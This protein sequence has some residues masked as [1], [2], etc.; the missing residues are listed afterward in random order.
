MRIIKRINHNAVLCVDS[1]GHDVVALGSG[2]GFPDGSN[3]VELQRIERTFYG[4]DDRYLDLMKDIPSDVLGF[5][6][7]MADVIRGVLSYELSPNFPLVLADHI[8]FMIK[9]TRGGMMTNMPLSYDIAQLYPLE[10][11]LATFVID[12]AE[13][14][15]DLPLKRSEVTGVALT[16]LNSVNSDTATAEEGVAVERILDGVTR[17]VEEK[18][19][20]IIDRDGMNYARFATHMHYLLRGLRTAGLSDKQD[21]HMLRQ[22]KNEVPDIV[23][24]ALDVGAFAE[25]E[26]GIHL[27]MSEFVYLAIHINRLYNAA[28][29]G[30][31]SASQEKSI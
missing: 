15:F 18:L 2:I 23:S 21:E 5:S 24:C 8:A 30:E 13:S 16:I 29:G 7:Q 27:G 22:L 25:R 19:S 1:K 11:K 26:A 10:W 20:I 6:A 9:R 4:V 14:T 17:T 12:R 31:V 28:K 3:E